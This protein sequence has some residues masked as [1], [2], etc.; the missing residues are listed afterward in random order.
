M[1]KDK[2]STSCFT[3]YS[4]KYFSEIFLRI[5]KKNCKGQTTE[6]FYCL[7]ILPTSKIFLFNAKVKSLLDFSP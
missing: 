6:P 2:L 7:S 3:P 4:L 1:F 5:K